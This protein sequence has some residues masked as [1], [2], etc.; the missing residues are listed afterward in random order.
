MRQPL[1]ASPQ[2][3]LPLLHFQRTLDSICGAASQ[4]GVSA[5]LRKRLAGREPSELAARAEVDGRVE[6]RMEIVVA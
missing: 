3:Q 5:L 1:P 2:P 6:R 4:A